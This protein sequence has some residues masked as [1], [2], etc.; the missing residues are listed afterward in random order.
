MDPAADP[1]PAPQC[2]VVRRRHVLL[3]AATACALGGCA[4]RRDRSAVDETMTLAD[5]RDRLEQD[6]AGTP[7]QFHWREPAG[8]GM[9]RVLQVVVPQPH[10]FE[11]GRVAV[12]P[13]LAALLDRVAPALRR[14]ARW[15][16]Q[17]LGPV[18]AR[19]PAAQGSER[20]AAV[21]DYLVMKGVPPGRFAALQRSSGGHTELRLLE[22]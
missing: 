15:S 14:Q 20:A 13:A 1:R 10:G 17:I 6:F 7:V 19:A 12:R 8:Q 18:D 5:L 11:A 2:G 22:R 4:T 16:L 9:A 3:G 21:R